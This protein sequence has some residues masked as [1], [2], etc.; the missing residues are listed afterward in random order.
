MIAVH[1]PDQLNL[2]GRNW[3]DNVL[4]R[5]VEG[6]KCSQL[7]LFSQE[8]VSSPVQLYAV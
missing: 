7:S 1:I 3:K 6:T 8:F 4:W 2:L 5:A